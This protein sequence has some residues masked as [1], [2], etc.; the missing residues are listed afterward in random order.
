MP[1]SHDTRHPR[2]HLTDIDIAK[3]LRLGKAEIPQQEIASLMNCSQKAVQHP[4]VTYTFETFQ[5]RNPRREYHQKTTQLEDSDIHQAL[6][7][8]SFTP[9]H[10]VTNIIRLPI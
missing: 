2:Q 7:H 8:N 3:I 1:E 6:I 10:D 4:L 5:R 9:L